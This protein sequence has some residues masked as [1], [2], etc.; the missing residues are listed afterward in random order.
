MAYVFE[1]A[2]MAPVQREVGQ[3]RIA[4]DG[5][6]LVYRS[7]HN[8]RVMDAQVPL[9]GEGAEPA[10]PSG[11]GRRSG[12]IDLSR[13]QTLVQP[14]QEWAQMYEEAWRLQ[15]EQFWDE[16]MSDVNWKVVHDRYAVL[17]KRVRT[18]GELSDI[19][20][21][22]QGELGT[23][24]AYEIGGDYRYPPPYYRGFLGAD[25]AWNEK[26]KGYA[27]QQILR[28]ESWSDNSDSPLA[29]P[30]VDIAVGDVVIAVNGRS[31]SRD[32]TI[33]ELLINNAGREIN[34]SVLR[35]KGARKNVVATTLRK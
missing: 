35:K 3:I 14:Q 34:L 1:E 27:V 9:P 13:A 12:W 10:P 30:G 29:V 5:Q 19:I 28:G 17:L 24:H 31:V 11:S 16:S 4:A 25:F 8:L 26:A 7:K 32:C 6:T 20:W 2:R 21:E 18:R 23:S 22:M 15:H 33:D